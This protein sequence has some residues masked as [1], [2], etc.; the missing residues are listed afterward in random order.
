MRIVFILM[1]SFALQL[2][3]AAHVNANP[4]VLEIQKND[5]YINMGYEDGLALNSLVTLQHVIEA[6]HPVTNERVRD[7]FPLGLMRV[8]NVGPKTSVVR[9]GAKLFQRVRVGDEVSLASEPVD[10]VDPWSIPRRSA[11]RQ[12]VQNANDHWKR[13]V[14]GA[15][16]R[17]AAEREIHAVWQ[18]TL[19]QPLQTRIALWQDYV[20]KNPK[21]RYRELVNRTVRELE[22]RM[23][24]EKEITA[25]SPEE[26]AANAALRHLA[27]LTDSR[28]EDD[29]VLH[30]APTR[31]YEGESVPLALLL[32]HPERLTKAWLYVRTR[33]EDSYEVQPMGKD[34][35]GYL[36]ATIAGPQAIAP[37]IEYFIEALEVGLEEPRPILG[38]SERPKRVVIDRSA[39]EEPPDRVGH[40]RVTLFTDYV[41]FDGPSTSYDQYLHAEVDFMYRFFQPVYSLRLGFGTI[42]GIGGPKDVIDLGA[43]CTIAGEYRCRRVGYNYAFTEIEER[44][45]DI[46]AVMLRVQWGSAYQDQAPMEGVGR[47]FFD[48]FGVRGRIRLGREQASNLVLGVSTTQRL[49]NMFEGAFT[50][51]VIPKFPV[52]LAV[53]VTDQPVLEDFGVRL[54]SDIGWRYVDWVYPS[55][56]I[57]YQARDIDHAGLSAGLA[58]NF[59]W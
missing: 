59:D 17:V 22:A 28:F 14:K 43:D 3:S 26:R 56:R 6:T 36:R 11:T 5:I 54:I 23:V 10:H 31:G 15:E 16:A 50:W 30:D 45:S 19:G 44:F 33:G 39:R 21:S 2:V 24:A 20:Q 37:G 8:V 55:L 48:A 35:D 57:A 46:V 29:S 40:S 41:D 9:A 25:V 13:E 42:S 58:A 47:E 49:G 18:A 34:G 27:I 52:V 53:Q 7:T 12:P 4:V 51:D 32:R 1:L 38:S